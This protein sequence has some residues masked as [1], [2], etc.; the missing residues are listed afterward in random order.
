VEP[1][2]NTGDVGAHAEGFNSTSVGVCLVGGV[3]A[4]NKAE[5]NFTPRQYIALQC[6]LTTLKREYSNAEIV[7]HRDLS[8][9]KDGDGVVEPHEWLKECP[10]FDVKKWLAGNRLLD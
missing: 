4:K 1:G 5:D 3:D 2:R 7:G 9:D 8:P 10:S 6:L